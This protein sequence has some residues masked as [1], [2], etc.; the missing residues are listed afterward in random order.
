MFTLSSPKKSFCKAIKLVKSLNPG[1]IIFQSID[2]DDLK[3]SLDMLP[4]ETVCNDL[5]ASFSV[6]SRL[7]SFYEVTTLSNRYPFHGILA[8]MFFVI[9]RNFGFVLISYLD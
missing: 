1:K 6:L 5:E 8:G 7:S 2:N 4:V 9:T 3:S